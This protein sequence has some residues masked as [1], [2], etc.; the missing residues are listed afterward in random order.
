MTRADLLNRLCALFPEPAYLEIGVYQGE[1]FLAIAAARK[2]GVDPNFAFDIDAAMHV[3]QHATLLRM[4]SD[5]FFALPAVVPGGYDVVFLDG[6]HTAEQTLRDLLNAI[7]VLRP[8]GVIV[9]DDMVPSSYH[10][11][12]PSSTLSIKL[13]EAMRDRDTSWMGDV[14][15]LGFFIES[16]LQQFSVATVGGQM[17]VWRAVRGADRMV[18]RT[19]EQVGRMGFEETRF[20]REVFNPCTL[21]EAI[22]LI[23][24]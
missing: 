4:T 2:I 7:L 12:L 24:G 17:L 6:M 14:Y 15:R 19:L 23:R 21:D 5:A 22:A 1:T 20:Q 18:K 3:Q 13:R 9:L 11:S 10:A 8:G 16:F